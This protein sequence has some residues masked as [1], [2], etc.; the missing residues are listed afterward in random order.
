M[1]SL[2]CL[3]IWCDVMRPIHPGLK[4]TAQISCD[5]LHIFPRYFRFTVSFS[6]V[7]TRWKLRLIVFWHWRPTWT[8]FS[9]PHLQLKRFVSTL[10]GWR[11]HT[12]VS[13][14]NRGLNGEKCNYTPEERRSKNHQATKQSSSLTN[15][16]S[17]PLQTFFPSIPER[18]GGGWGPQVMISTAGNEYDGQW[19]N[20][21]PVSGS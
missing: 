5:I 18:V 4:P 17:R 8:Q 20:A 13:E 9:S 16:D 7:H 14:H 15:F 12:L 6:I 3:W 21:S 10:T 19:R 1:F 2:H 11:F